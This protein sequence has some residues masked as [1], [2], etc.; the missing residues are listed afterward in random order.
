MIRGI[1]ANAEIT[2]SFELGSVIASLRQHNAVKVEDFEKI[3]SAHGLE[4]Y[5]LDEFGL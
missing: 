5:M 4:R 2:G 3:L 1:S